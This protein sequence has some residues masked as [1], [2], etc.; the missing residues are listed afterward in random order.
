[1]TKILTIG[2]T[3]GKNTWKKLTLDE[4]DKIIFI[5]DYVDSW[6][7][8]D[9]DMVNNLL[10]IIEFKKS[11]QNNVILLVG[12]H[13]L[14]YF[15]KFGHQF[16]GSSGYRPSIAFTLGEIFR[17]YKSFFQYAY[18][19]EDETRKYLWTHAGVTNSWYNKIFYTEFSSQNI[20]SEQ[21]LTVADELNMMFAEKLECMTQVGWERGGH[22]KYGCPLWVDIKEFTARGIPLRGYHQ[23]VGH[24][25]VNDIQIHTIDMDTEIVF[26]DCLNKQE[27]GYVITI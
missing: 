12:N 3:H 7:T 6:D 20:L 18:Q 17:Q 21:D 27:K 25:P 13:E 8:S 15:P 1:M 9:E 24:N 14:N 26:I 19:L 22:Y 4:Y 5:G 10:D 11:N 16:Y 23:I 2:D